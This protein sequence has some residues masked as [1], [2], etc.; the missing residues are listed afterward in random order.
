MLKSRLPFKSLIEKADGSIEARFEEIIVS[1]DTSIYAE[2]R[3]EAEF[4]KLAEKET[5]FE[6]MNRI[7]VAKSEEDNMATKLAGLKALYCLIECDKW[8]N[9]KEF[10]Q[11]ISI[12]NTEFV[13][14]MYEL[15][16]KVVN[17]SAAKPKNF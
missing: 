9:Y 4:P 11:S 15:F 16:K 10:L 12:D 5:I 6:Y 14:K 8:T 17:A 3:W 13:N 1:V 2:E 7:S